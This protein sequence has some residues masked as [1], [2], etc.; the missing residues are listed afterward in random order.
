MDSGVVD[1]V[2]VEEAVCDAVELELGVPEVEEDALPVV[3]EDAVPV[4]E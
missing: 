2:D 3:E 1:G 4:A